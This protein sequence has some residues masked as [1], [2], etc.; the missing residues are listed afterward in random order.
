M[1]IEGEIADP[2]AVAAWKASVASA[3]PKPIL[4][5]VALTPSLQAGFRPGK[6]THKV[7][8]DRI[9]TMLEHTG[10][11]PVALRNLLSGIGLDRSL[12]AVLSEEAIGAAQ[13]NMR[14]FFGSDS[15]YS[16]M[17]LSDREGV[18]STGIAGFAQGDFTQPGA[19]ERESAGAALNELFRPFLKDSGRF[20]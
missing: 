5:F 17:L 11:M 20:H 9:Q 7:A 19:E 10:E 15:L 18:R 6:I 13:N 8:V 14:S 3:P 12:L 1:K 16:A 4:D 2:R